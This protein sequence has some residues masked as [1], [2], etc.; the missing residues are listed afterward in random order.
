MQI[1]FAFQN[2]CNS[3]KSL[4]VATTEEIVR[5]IRIASHQCRR[6]DPS[7]TNK[8]GRRCP[9]LFGSYPSERCRTQ[10]SFYA[11]EVR[12]EKACACCCTCVRPCA[13]G[14]VPGGRASAMPQ[15]DE[16]ANRSSAEGSISGTGWQYLTGTPV[17]L[18]IAVRPNQSCSHSCSQSVP[19][20]DRGNS[21]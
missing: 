13:H 15:D 17:R 1:R 2:E 19:G 14:N 20:D 12:P 11:S 10:T 4:E 8:M 3:L 21:L 7:A 16:L 5:V 9:P 6:V 18:S